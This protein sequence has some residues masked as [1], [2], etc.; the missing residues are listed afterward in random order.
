MPVVNKYLPVSLGSF[1]DFFFVFFFFTSISLKFKL[2]SFLVFPDPAFYPHEPIRATTC[3][4]LHS[5]LAALAQPASQPA[6]R[7]FLHV[8][9]LE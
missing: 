5:P 2:H 4:H 3:P 6:S 8:N 9:K 1:S 7:D